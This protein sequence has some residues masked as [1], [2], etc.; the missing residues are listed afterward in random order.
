MDWTRDIPNITLDNQ[1]EKK[2]KCYWITF[3]RETSSQMTLR[4]LSAYFS[5]QSEYICR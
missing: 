3:G 4:S 5:Q 2:K 1:G